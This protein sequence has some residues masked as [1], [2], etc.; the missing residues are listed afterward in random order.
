MTGEPQPVCVSLSLSVCLCVCACV[1][2]CSYVCALGVHNLLA[3]C[4]WRLQQC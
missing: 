3:G 4:T 1:C 2:V